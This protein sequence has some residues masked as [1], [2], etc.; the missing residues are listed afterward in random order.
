MSVEQQVR[1]HFAADANRFD[2]I[3]EDDKSAFAR[4]IDNVWRGVV[5]RR[6][7][8]TLE[9]LE[10]L[11]GKRVLDVGCGSG[12]Y[13]LAYA[14]R[15]AK[16]VVGVDFAAPMIELAKKHAQ[17]LGIE[18]Q[19]DFR[20]G[21]FPQAVPDGP[22]DAATAMGFFDYVE[23]PVTI[24]RRMRELTRE[25]MIMSFPKVFEW[26]I[27]LR[28]LRFKLINKCP[29]FLYTEGNLHKIL[30]AAGITQYELIKMDRDYIVI[31]HL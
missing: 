4:W 14:E 5:R 30:A 18:G 26:R 13:C 1:I 17:R 24:I 6:F 19:C 7:D 2:A 12:R 20:V 16:N 9:R 8:L 15:G 22:F 3:Y 29:L 11:A 28:W 10:P 23:E 31:A 27:P 25:T 21:T